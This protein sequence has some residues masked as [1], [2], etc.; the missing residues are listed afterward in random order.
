MPLPN[1][2]NILDLKNK[3]DHI[4]K[5]SS[6]SN[7]L[8][9]LH[10]KNDGISTDSYETVFV[11]QVLIVKNHWLVIQLLK[12]SVQEQSRHHKDQ[13]VSLPLRAQ[14]PMTKGSPGGFSASADRH[15]HAR[16]PPTRVSQRDP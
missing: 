3:H 7:C 16:L 8:L 11:F 9:V 2:T 13:S 6:I 10:T 1:K 14:W 5:K 4:L 15:T 12:Q